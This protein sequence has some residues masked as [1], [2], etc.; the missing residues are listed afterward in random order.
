MKLIGGKSN[1]NYK[2]SEL[3]MPLE[4]T[5]VFN[6][7]G[8]DVVRRGAVWMQRN[9]IFVVHRNGLIGDRLSSGAFG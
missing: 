4:V 1:L 3:M 7:G 5:S 2:R 9:S 6:S 8:C